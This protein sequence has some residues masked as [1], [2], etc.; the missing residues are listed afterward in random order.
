M[1]N[2]AACSN[3]PLPCRQDGGNSSAIHPRFTGN[4]NQSLNHIDVLI[5][6]KSSLE[7]RK[8]KN[9]FWHFNPIAF[10]F[11]KWSFKTKD[12]TYDFFF[13]GSMH[14]DVGEKLAWDSTS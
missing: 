5:S 13:N 12:R 3:L 1:G 2:A 9:Y 11:Q 4:L 7:Q 6:I 8:M 14:E 10:F